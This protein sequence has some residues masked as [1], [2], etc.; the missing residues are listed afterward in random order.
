M[1]SAPSLKTKVAVGIVVGA[2]LGFLDGMS[3]YLTPAVRPL[4]FLIVLGSTLKGFVTGLLTGLVAS[5]IRKLWP[6]IGIGLSL[7]AIL[8]FFA[9][10]FTPDPKGNRYYLQV[11][12]PG[13][14][15]G[16]VVGF[17]T[18]RARNSRKPSI[19]AQRS[20]SEPERKT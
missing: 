7:G 8:S 3:S 5:R 16:A 1:S 6:T 13:A 12:L 20:K 10:T 2:A 19:D 11:M 17:A 15:L 4:F 9:A 14:V 18:Q